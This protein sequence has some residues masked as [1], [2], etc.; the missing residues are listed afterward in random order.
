LVVGRS[1]RGRLGDA[2][3]DFRRSKACACLERTAAAVSSGAR[4][5]AYKE[6]LAPQ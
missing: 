1:L 6:L 5:Q 2:T 4:K 3:S